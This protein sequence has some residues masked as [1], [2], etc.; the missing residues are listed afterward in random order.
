[1]EFQNLTLLTTVELPACGLQF[2]FL[3]PAKAAVFP[4]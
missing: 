2:S 4:L 1:M 3:Y